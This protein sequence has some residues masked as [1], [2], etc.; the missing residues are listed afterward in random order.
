MLYICETKPGT[1]KA[2]RVIRNA[3][4]MACA[5]FLSFTIFSPFE[6]LPL[7][8]PAPMGDYKMK[9]IS[10]KEVSLNTIRKDK[11]LLVIFS[12]NTCPY[13]KLSEKR[14]KQYSDFC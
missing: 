10:G 1:M 7:N 8:S 14:I 3:G 9:D 11:G 2:T 4:L 12:C 6:E 5:S 13:V